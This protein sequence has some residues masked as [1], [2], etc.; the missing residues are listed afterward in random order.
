MPDNFS[1][2]NIGLGF[3]SVIGCILISTFNIVYKKW[4]TSKVNE[5]ILIENMLSL[6]KVHNSEN[7]KDESIG[8]SINKSKR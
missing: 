7:K 8:N 4:I 1:L 6:E 2:S 5:N 3:F